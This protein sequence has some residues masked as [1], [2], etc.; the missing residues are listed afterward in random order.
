MQEN[1]VDTKIKSNKLQQQKMN[2]TKET[3]DELNAVVKVKL[4]PEDYSD[5]VEKILKDYQKKANVP[6]FRPGKVPSGMIKKMYGKSILVD[7]INK[8]LYDSLNGFI[9]DNKLEVLGNPLP[10]RNEA[11]TIDWDNQKEFEFSYD[12]GLAPQFE[13]ELTPKEQFDYLQVKVDDETISKYATDIARRYGKVGNPEISQDSDLLFGDFN[14]VDDK[15]ALIENGI[16]K[17][18]TLAVDTIK[19]EKLKKQFI[20][21]TKGAKLTLNPADLSENKTDLAAMLGISKEQAEDLKSNFS[22]TLTNISRIEPAELTE[23]FFGKVYG[24]EVKTIEQFREKIKEELTQMYA[25]DSDR[26]LKNDIVLRLI[27][28]LKIE[29]PDEFL[30]RW[31]MAVNEQPLTYEQVDS[32]YNAYSNGLRWQLIENKIFRNNDVK[33]S[34][35]EVKEYVRGLVREQFARYNQVEMQDEDLEG[36]VTRVLSNEEEAKKLYERLYEI[37]LMDLFKRNFTLN[38]KEVSVEELYKA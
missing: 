22:F 4:G 23:D 20:G 19:D 28:K 32:E 7:E 30:K 37:R 2:F 5:R 14:E 13:V 31:L 21:L 3:I 8:I 6:G 9:A 12:L 35:D 36:T 33:V 25:A 15:G 16:S 18:T 27:E 11:E 1:V 26:K 10:K 34:A 17:S 38:N 29:L 24:P